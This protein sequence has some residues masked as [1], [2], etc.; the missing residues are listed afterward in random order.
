MLSEQWAPW[1]LLQNTHPLYMDWSL[2]VC[3]LCVL[4]RTWMEVTNL[5]W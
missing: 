4:K 1:L 2:G 3:L 5:L